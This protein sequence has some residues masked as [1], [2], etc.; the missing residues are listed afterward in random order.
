VAVPRRDLYHARPCPRCPHANRCG[1]CTAC[2]DACPT[3]AFPAPYQLDARACISY[4][5]IEHKG[6][7]DER[8]RAA[9][10]NRIYGCDDC[11]AV[12]PWNSFAR[13][14]HDNHAFLP[15]AELVAPRL[16]EL[17]ALDDATFRRSSQAPPSSGSAA[18]AWCATASTRRETAAMR[19]VPTVEGLCRS[20]PVVAEAAVWALGVLKK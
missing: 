9:L 6:P 7:I 3:G 5:T 1:S 17:L 14:A 20:R 15:R 8:Y 2:Q 10:G 4:L 19:L 18:T 13:A 12:C 11:L 16:A